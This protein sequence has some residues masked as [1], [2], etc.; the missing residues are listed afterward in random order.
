MQRPLIIT[1][2]IVVILLVLGAWVYLL[3]FGAPGDVKE[4]PT[5][6]GFDITPREAVIIEPPTEEGYT[7][8]TSSGLQQLTTRPVAGYTSITATTSSTTIVRYVEQGTG[9]IYDIDLETGAEVL[10]SRTTIP[11]VREAVFSPDGTTVAL[12]S[13]TGYNR[14]TFV[15]NINTAEELLEGENIVPNADNIALLEKDIVSYTSQD[16][17]GLFGYSYNLESGDLTQKFYTPFK[18]VTVIWN[19]NSTYLYNRPATDLLGYLYKITA[20]S[21]ET[22]NIAGYGL[23]AKGN[24]NLVGYS[25]YNNDI[26]VSMIADQNTG[27]TYPI[28]TLFIPEKCDFS[29]K[30]DNIRM[31]CAAP[32]ENKDFNLNK[33][34][35]GKLTSKDYLWKIQ[36]EANTAILISDLEKDSG[37]QIDVTGL[38]V[39]DNDTVI[40]FTN[41]IDNTLWKFDI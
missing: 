27:Q 5:N 25:K 15:G 32:L 22:T 21:Y 33:W 31:W 9:H 10:V 11:R 4:V 7:V 23:V 28:P 37:R 8:D 26:N 13:I 41:K 38:L 16:K 1:I 39:S 35:Q 6:L 19:K 30:S 40:L 18:A 2:G 14:D 3:F 24:G 34:Y 12:T 29:K 36:A 17:S 20:G